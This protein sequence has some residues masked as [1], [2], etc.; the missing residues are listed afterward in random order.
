MNIFNS[1][2]I[3]HRQAMHVSTVFPLL[4]VCS[5]HYYGSDCNSSCGQCK[6]NDLC[7]N[8]TGTCP[9]GCNGHWTGPNCNGKQNIVTVNDCLITP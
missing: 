4:P 1:I 7:N 3:L 5:P 2:I 8:V 6:G 9:N